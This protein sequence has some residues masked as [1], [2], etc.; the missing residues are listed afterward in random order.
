MFGC[1]GFAGCCDEGSGW[2]GGEGGD[3]VAVAVELFVFG[4]EGVAGE[5]FLKRGVGERGE[6]GEG[7]GGGGRGVVGDE[8]VGEGSGWC[9]GGFVGETEH[10]DGGGCGHGGLWG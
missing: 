4:P 6:D 3:L 2:G 10:G 1:A 7:G 9:V 5:V 8:A